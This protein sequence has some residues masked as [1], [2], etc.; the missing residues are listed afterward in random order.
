MNFR[1]RI[2]GVA[3]ILLLGLAAGGCGGGAHP[4]VRSDFVEFSPE[5]RQSIDAQ[6]HR[7]YRIQANDIL[8]VAFLNLADLTQTGVL[9]LPDGAINLVGVDR[10]E[11][12]GL[13]LA[14]ADSLITAAYAREYKDPQLSVIVAETRGH[15]VYVLGEVRNPGLV[16]LPPG[17][18]GVVGAVTLAG[19]FTADAAEEGAVLVR[20]TP[21]GYLAQ[22]IDL[23]GFQT[24]AFSDLATVNLAPY[25]I[26]YVPR[27]RIGDFAYFT[28]SVLAGLVSITRIAAD[29][30][31]LSNG[32]IGRY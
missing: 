22:E 10:L 28:K 4:V 3:L 19:G 21:E 29:I 1:N 23:S 27:S 9:V 2:I 12:A 8:K 30:N 26:I 17:G 6:S 5:Q 7:E 18:L 14:E 11:V 32:T 24:T 31:Y 15:Q 13:T 16:T 20:V 25:D